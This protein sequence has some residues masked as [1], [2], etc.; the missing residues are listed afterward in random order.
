MADVT[1]PIHRC[2]LTMDQRFV[3]AALSANGINGADY[4]QAGPSPGRPLATV[5]GSVDIDASGDMSNRVVEVYTV[6]GGNP[7]AAV[8]IAGTLIPVGPGEAWRYVGDPLYRG[9]EAPTAIGEFEFLDYTTTASAHLYPH[10]VSRT[11]GRMFAVEQSAQR[12]VKVWTRPRGG[13]WSQVGT[14]YDAGSAVYAAPT[15]ACPCLVTLP[16]NR[17]AC[18]FVAVSGSDQYIS[19]SYSSDN[20]ATWTQ[21][22]ISDAYVGTILA[23]GGSVVR[24]RAAYSNGQMALFV[25]HAGA[26]QDSVIQLASIDDGGSFVLVGTFAATTNGY[27]EVVALPNGA[28]FCV[29][30]IETNRPTTGVPAPATIAYS[31]RIAS[32]FDLAMS[33]TP[34]CLQTDAAATQWGT[35]AAGVLTDGE[36]ALTVDDAGMLWA[37]GMDFAATSTGMVARSS[38]GGVT[39]TNT[40]GAWWHG[41]DA[42]THPKLVSACAQGGR[43]AV[44]SVHAAN[45]GTADQSLSCAYL[46]GSTT[47]PRPSTNAIIVIPDYQSIPAVTWLP[48]DLPENT[49]A[50]WTAATTGPGPTITLTGQGLRVQHTNIADSADWTATPTT[51]NAQGL[52]VHCDLRAAAIGSSAFCKVR[53]GEAGPSSYEVRAE[54]TGSAIV[55]RDITG[56]VDIATITTAAGST[57]VQVIIAIGDTAGGAAS[58]CVQAWYRAWGPDADREYLAIGAS[59]ALVQGASTTDRI[60][61]G[62]MINA[63]TADV[64]VRLIDYHQGTGTGGAPLYLAANT[65]TAKLLGQPIGPAPY[66]LAET[67]IRLSGA[68]GPLRVGDHWTISP[69][70]QYGIDRIDPLVSG[71]PDA[72]W[73]SLADNVSQRIV[74]TMAEATTIE[75]P[76]VGVYLDGCNFST[77]EWCGWNGAAWVVL[78]TIDLRIGT[79]LK[80]TRAGEVIQCNP[81]GGA[82]I[83]DYV[84]RDALRGCTWST[85][86]GGVLRRIRT[87]TGGRWSAS[88]IIST[89]RPTIILDA[90]TVGDPAAG[91]TAEIWSPRAA[92]ILRGQTTAY[93]RY[94]LHIPATVTADGHYTIGTLIVG[95]LL[96]IGDPDRER[97]LATKTNVITTEARGGQ[98]TQRRLGKPRRSVTL[99]W[100]DGIETSNVHDASPDYAND[101][102]SGDHVSTPA[103]IP[104]DLHALL[105]VNDV[106]PVVYLPQVPVPATATVTCITA[107]ELMLFGDIVTDTLQTDVVVG[108]EHTGA[109]SGEYVRVGSVLLEECL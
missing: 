101:Y 1:P 55:L 83:T 67:G 41:L 94:S 65:T 10:V 103:G 16:G 77:A 26:V 47:V 46:G 11:D 33:V 76:F 31:R 42:N 14:V 22:Q 56:A 72:Q 95:P 3:S 38:D 4:T 61:F 107:R 32:A 12:Y 75:S 44:V 9:W 80:Y 29:A 25:Y 8:P 6:R 104:G 15:R 108:D 100:T 85:G 23:I 82:S 21:S 34:V 64:Y 98:R 92:M 51:T 90:F 7:G 39:W 45:P 84:E 43:L 102:T 19:T 40:S 52:L 50:T 88:G 36:I 17:L 79:V 60:M 2:L 70:Y 71:S 28:G 69:A 20:G 91:A 54:V 24:I 66:P 5:T 86:A 99:A 97:Q 57:G 87:N 37:V 63:A 27:P 35:Q 96:V 53:I 48:F 105:A 106:A 58:G 30:T 93:S 109:G 18:I 62:S 73:R 68:K 81:T 59:T 74:W 49:G 13:A 78:G 89:T